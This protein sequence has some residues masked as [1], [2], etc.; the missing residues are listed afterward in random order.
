VAAWLNE[1]PTY[2]QNIRQKI[3]DIREAGK[4]GALEKV[5]KTAEDVKE[6]FQKQ[7]EPARVQAKPREVV[8]KAEESFRVLQKA[9]RQ[10]AECQAF[11]LHYCR[12]CSATSDSFF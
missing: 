4:G 1:L 8:V 2:R 3:G 12:S 7:D 6:E 9:E 10:K 5:Q 11:V